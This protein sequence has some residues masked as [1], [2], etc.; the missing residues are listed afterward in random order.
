[1]VPRAFVPMNLREMM[2]VYLD[3]RFI[4]NNGSRL[5]A[6]GPMVTTPP[7]AVND[8]ARSLTRTHFVIASVAW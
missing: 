1:M 5:L 3:Y 8:E 7:P 4:L 6:G 2:S